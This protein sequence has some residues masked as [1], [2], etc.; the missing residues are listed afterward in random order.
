MISLAISSLVYLPLPYVQ[1]VFRPPAEASSLILQVTVGCS[2]NKCSFCD[3]YTQP[4]QAY[5]QKSLDEIESDLKL[6]AELAGAYGQAVRRV[7]LADGDA[8]GQSTARL[9]SILEQI[10]TQLPTV[11]R[12]SSY[13]LPRNV[14][15]KS[16]A[17]LRSLQS[18]GLRTLYVGCESGDDEVLRC[19]GK[20]ET[21]ASSAE[22]LAKLHEAGLKTS[23]MILHGLGGQALSAQH[24]AGSAALIKRAPPTYLSTLVVSFPKGSERHAAGFGAEGRCFTPLSTA[25]LLAEQRALLEQ[26]DGLDASVIFRSDHASNYLPLKGTLPRHRARLLAELSDAQRGDLPLR[27]EWARGL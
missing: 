10:Q 11:S 26:L 27:P 21:Q 22:A 24:V 18:L 2:W 3:M 19:V 9:A 12:V 16:V 25:E 23:V 8:M 13:C 17:D 6:A 4:Q 7:F 14:R 20:G 5:R 1:P 15:G